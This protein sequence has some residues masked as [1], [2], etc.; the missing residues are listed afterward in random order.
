[1]NKAVAVVASATIAIIAARAARMAVGCKLTVG[2]MNTTATVNN[3]TPAT[4]MKVTFF[5]QFNA[6]C[7][8]DEVKPSVRRRSAIIW[9]TGAQEQSAA[10]AC[11]LATRPM[12]LTS[13]TTEAEVMKYRCYGLAAAGALVLT[14]LSVGCAG[15]RYHL[16]PAPS[17][18]A[19]SGS[20]QIRTDKNGNDV[21][22]LKVKHLAEPSALT[23]P[24][25]TY[26]VWIQPPGKA[27]INQGELRV[28]NNLNGE[29]K[30][31]TPYKRF[32]LFVTAENQAKVT[33]PTGQPLLRQEIGG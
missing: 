7:L 18:P 29:F 24:R 25:S 31:A 33:A 9:A 8:C 27:A 17:V 23:P 20:V 28:D 14:L 5:I 16:V 19:A 12:Q 2:A 15:H 30:T 21:I 26:V 1:M 10:E 6:K 11:T 22:D 4:R 3:N 13:I 32:Q